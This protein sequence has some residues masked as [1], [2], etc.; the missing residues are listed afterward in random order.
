MPCTERVLPSAVLNV[1]I[2]M[3]T[4]NHSLSMETAEI[5]REMVFCS[6]EDFEVFPTPLSIG[7]SLSCPE[8]AFE[9]KKQNG[10]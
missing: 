3:E 5:F 9:K 10:V 6:Q 7:D 2:R 4:G 1:A 8:I